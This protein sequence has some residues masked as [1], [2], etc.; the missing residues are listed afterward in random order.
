MFDLWFVLLLTVLGV[1]FTG[2]G[3][4]LLFV[5]VVNLFVYVQSQ[6]CMCVLVAPES[7]C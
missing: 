6:D 4:A 1:C 5:C 7:H 3:I 2:V